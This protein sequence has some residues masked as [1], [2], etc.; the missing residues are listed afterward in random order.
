[1]IATARQG[2]TLDALCW[3]MY[4]ATAGYV[5]QIL[6]DNPGIAA[7]GPFLPHGT[8]VVMPDPATSTT[9]NTKTT[10]ATVNLWD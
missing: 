2:E 3:R 7:L 5:E 8:Q 6:V 9:A 1:M 10:A 4:G